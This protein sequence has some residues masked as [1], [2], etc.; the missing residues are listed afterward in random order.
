VAI[1]SAHPSARREY[2]EH[3]GTGDAGDADD[4]ISKGRAHL[5]RTHHGS[6]NKRGGG[7]AMHPKLRRILT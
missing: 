5:A 3:T 6:D 7:D 2:D 1:G 4:N